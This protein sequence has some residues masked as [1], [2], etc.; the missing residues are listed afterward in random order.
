[1]SEVVL[2]VLREA[3]VFFLVL[4]PVPADPPQD[5]LGKG[6]LGIAVPNGLVI[7]RVE[8]GYP[9][10]RAGL[11][12]GDVLVRIGTFRPQAFK[13]V[14]DRVCSYRPG[15]VVEIEFERNGSRQT[16]KVTLVARPPELDVANTLPPM[17]FVDD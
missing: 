6:Y 4:A 1:M 9:A 16:A 10:D 11:R 8:P 13:E 15:A 12:P 5:P 2:A 17:P 7:E 3:A 14:I